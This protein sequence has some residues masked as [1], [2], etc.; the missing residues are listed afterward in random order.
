MAK[1]PRIDDYI[2][3]AAPFARPILSHLRALVHHAIPDLNETIKWGMP[4][5]T[6]KGKNLAGMASFKAHAA[7]IIHTEGRQGEAMGQF[8]KLTGLADLPDDVVLSANLQAARERLLSATKKPR[9]PAKPKPEITMPADFTAA[10]S[11]AARGHF[12]GFSP[13]QRREYLEW[14]TEAKRPETRA[15]RI[16]EAAEWLTEGKKRNWKYESC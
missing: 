7:F 9:E 1:D 13:A 11:P 16:A 6:V 3:K 10:L 8:G 15:K 12:D 2:A 5:F 4:H 14:I